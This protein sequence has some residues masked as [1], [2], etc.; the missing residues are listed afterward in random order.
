MTKAMQ[1]TVTQKL[2]LFLARSGQVVAPWSSVEEVMDRLYSLLY[3]R[4]DQVGLWEDLAALLDSIQ[5][6]ARG[7]LAAPDAEI[8][9]QSRVAGIAFDAACPS[10]RAADGGIAGSRTYRPFQ[11]ALRFPVEVQIQNQKKRK[12]TLLRPL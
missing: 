11:R 7:M 9:S 10:L 8:L 3:Q 2:R 1:L 4:R 5:A 12:T 6:D